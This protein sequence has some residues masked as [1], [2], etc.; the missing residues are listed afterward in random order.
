MAGS[1]EG[2]VKM[3]VENRESRPW[4]AFAVHILTASG[5]ALA[6]LALFAAANRD[7]ILMFWWLGAALFIDGIDGALARR[8]KLAENLPRWSGEVLDCVVDFTTYVFVPAYAIATCGLFSLVLGVPLGILIV[9]TS[10]IYFADR[11]MKTPDNYFRGFPALWNAGAFYLLLWKPG[12]WVAATA[13]V[14]LA[15]LTFMPVRTIHPFRVPHLRAVNAAILILWALLAAW[16][17]FQNLEPGLSVAIVLT[18]LGLYFLAGA[19]W[20][21]QN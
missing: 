21:R 10:A 11:E 16:A 7:Y 6:L 20:R 19:F 13:I 3:S 18:A 9:V 8:L 15:V 17:L 4:P 5:A 1:S 12:A 2:D 14:I